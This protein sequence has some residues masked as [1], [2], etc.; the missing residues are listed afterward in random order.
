MKIDKFTGDY[1]F[2]SNFF[3]CDV[4]YLGLTYRSSEAAYQAA[5]CKNPNERLAFLWL[6]PSMAKRYGK[7]V[8][9]RPDWDEVKKRIMRDIVYLKFS[10]WPDLREKLLATGEAE[11]IEGNTWGDT[12]WGVC[13]GVGENN[14]GKI[15]MEVRR[16]FRRMGL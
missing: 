1:Y 16:E 6:T 15:L 5:K 9:I 11:L 3:E 13:N 10:Q 4:E 8:E 2:L 7:M 14:L 12:Y